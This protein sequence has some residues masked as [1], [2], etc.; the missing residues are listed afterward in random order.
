MPQKIG[1]L[2][3]IMGVEKASNTLVYDRQCSFGLAGTGRS[4]GCYRTPPVKTL[5]ER[6]SKSRKDHTVTQQRRNRRAGTGSNK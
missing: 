3:L 5:F 2:I 1:S 4:P 6:V